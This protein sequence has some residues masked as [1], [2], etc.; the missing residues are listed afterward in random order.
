MNL[1]GFL[2]SIVSKDAKSRARIWIDVER[3]LTGKT[4]VEA[5]T[6]KNYI[7]L[8]LSE[9]FLKNSQEWLTDRY[10]LVYSLI[11]LDYGNQ[12]VEFANVSGKNKFEIKQAD[13]NTSILRNY[14]LT[15]ILPFHG[16]GVEIDLGLASMERSN[17]VLSFAKTV[18]DIAGTLKLSQ[19]SAAA[20]ITSA[21]AGGVQ[22]LL[23]ADGTVTKLAA[24][25][26]F[27]NRS[28]QSGYLF[29]SGLEADAIDPKTIWM[30]SDGVRTGP[31]K[32]NLKALN[33]QDYMVL[34]IQVTDHRDDWQSL[35]EIGTPL[36]SAIEAKLSGRDAEA[37]AL[38][39][40]AK[41]AA[42]RHKGLTRTDAARVVVAVSSYFND[43][44]AVMTTFNEAKTEG[45]VAASERGN[46]HLSAAM[47]RLGN[48]P[49]PPLEDLVIY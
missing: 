1:F 4:G 47:A 26:L 48:A 7:Q 39:V 27:N 49:V 42:I 22:A 8:I 21:V 14:G 3:D 31:D 17:M 19:I 37:Q 29:L 35:S 46:L 34:Q 24:H 25:D 30:T 13:I 10:P 36:D 38:L 43:Q 33:P 15:S 32:N 23:G 20:E 28:I 40:Q 45:T 2:G 5:V 41:M 18:S 11:A 16:G 44:T 6:E 12:H 9:M